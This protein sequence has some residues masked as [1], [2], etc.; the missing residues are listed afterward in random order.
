[1][2]R[3]LKELQMMKVCEIIGVL[4]RYQGGGS[5]LVFLRAMTEKF[6]RRWEIRVRERAE[7]ACVLRDWNY[8][9]YWENLKSID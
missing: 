9:S 2:Q 7:R 8:P 1:M 5:A 3:G 6:Q 4:M